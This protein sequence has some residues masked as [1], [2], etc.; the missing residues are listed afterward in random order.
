MVFVFSW[1]YI[2]AAVAALCAVG[3][4]VGFFMMNKK[5]EKLL[6][7]FKESQIKE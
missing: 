1:W 6:K 5:D 7:D 3:C 4:L 2:V